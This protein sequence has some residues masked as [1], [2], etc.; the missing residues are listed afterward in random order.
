MAAALLLTPKSFTSEYSLLPALVHLKWLAFKQN[1]LDLV[2]FG[3]LSNLSLF[4]KNYSLLLK[5]FLL[6][7]IFN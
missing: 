6:T 2:K 1:N 4:L 5:A 7:S 3:A